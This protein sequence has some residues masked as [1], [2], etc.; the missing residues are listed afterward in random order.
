MAG[1][2]F[3]AQRAGRVR[4]LKFDANAR[5]KIPTQAKGGLEWATRS[6]GVSRCAM[7][8]V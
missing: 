4:F 5:A 8:R 1:S 2:A 6:K 7:F 3:F